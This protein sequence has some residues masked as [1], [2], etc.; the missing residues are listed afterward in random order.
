MKL[1]Q[2]YVAHLQIGEQYEGE[3][4]NHLSKQGFLPDHVVAKLAECH[5]AFYNRKGSPCFI[6]QSES[7]AY[8]FYTSEEA[9]SKNRHDAATKK[10]NRT[11]R[12]YHKVTKS[13]KGGARVMHKS[14]H[15]QRDHALKAFKLLSAADRKWFLQQIAK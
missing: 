14:E 8:Y 13:K 9:T 2:L 5:A 6:S 12:K 4:H 10:W 1:Y 7:G 15:G 3:L 11:I